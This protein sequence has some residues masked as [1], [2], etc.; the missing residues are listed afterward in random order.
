KGFFIGGGGDMSKLADLM[1]KNFDPCAAW[2][3]ALLTDGSGNFTHTFKVPDT[4][5]RYR[6][7]AVAHQQA[8][9]FGHVESAIVVKK[10]LMLEP[11][12]PR[13]ANQTDTFNSQVLV[14]NA[15]EFSGT[16]EIKFSTGSGPETQHV[17]PTGSTV[18]TVTLAAGASTTVIFPGRA[19]ST[20][21]AVLTFQ[22]TPVSLDKGE[23]TDAVRHKLSDAV[24][25]RFQVNYPM[26]MLRQTKLV[27]LSKPGARQNLRD[28]LDAKLLGGQGTVE[29]GFARSPLVEAAGSIDFLLS[30]PYG[31]VEQTTSSLIPWLA[32]EDLSPVIPR[33]AKIPEAKVKAAIQ[34]GA[35][36]LLSMQ[37]P[38]GGFSYWPGASQP[39]PWATAYAGMG[40]MMAAEK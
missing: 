32:V 29:L 30:Y 15:S 21:E 2:A 25:S 33:F 31:C 34:S 28:S 27:N 40:L 9:R 1:R 26:P 22:A 18:E 8:A 38:D 5:T 16:W 14:Q 24:E 3:P 10:D 7:I 13:F 37:L 11:K 39:A 35:D 4:L 6:V 12:T 23:L 19:D 20:G 17:S 36:R